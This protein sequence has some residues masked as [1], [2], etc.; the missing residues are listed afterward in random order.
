M[1][2]VHYTPR[3]LPQTDRSEIGLVF[4]DPKIDPQGNDGRSPRSTWT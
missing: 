1:F 3:E 4:A 2:Q